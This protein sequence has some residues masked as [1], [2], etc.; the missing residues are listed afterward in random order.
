MTSPGWTV[1]QARS[2]WPNYSRQLCSTWENVA[3]LQKGHETP[4]LAFTS[5]CSD[6]QRDTRGVRVSFLPL[7][8]LRISFKQIQASTITPH[9]K[10][11]DCL[12]QSDAPVGPTERAL[13]ISKC[14]GKSQQYRFPAICARG[15][16]A[17]QR[18]PFCSILDLWS[19]MTCTTVKSDTWSI[20]GKKKIHHVSD[21]HPVK[22]HKDVVIKEKMRFKIHHNGF[23]YEGHQITLDGDSIVGNDKL[24][25]RNTVWGMFLILLSF[26]FSF[27]AKPE[28]EGK[29]ATDLLYVLHYHTVTW[30]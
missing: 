23:R 22:H 20:P 25:R 15:H 4:S 6:P 3:R 7:F 29:S 8:R 9:S 16:T 12:A 13:P 10:Q 26:C 27:S 2:S 17:C 28:G 5:Y 1:K 30:L 19:K 21:K 14:C 24:L 11:I 18:W